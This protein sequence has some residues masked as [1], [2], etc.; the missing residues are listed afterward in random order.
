MIKSELKT[1]IAEEITKQSG[2]I[3]TDQ[4]LADCADNLLLFFDILIEADKELMKANDSPAQRDSDN[5]D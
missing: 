3:L 1:A 4:E 2:Q 5:S